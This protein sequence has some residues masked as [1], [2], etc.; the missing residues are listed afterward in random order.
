MVFNF[1]FLL[2]VI[3]CIL[4][5]HIFLFWINANFEYYKKKYFT[6]QNKNLENLI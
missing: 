5:A 1:A 3:V 4:R 6:G 2:S